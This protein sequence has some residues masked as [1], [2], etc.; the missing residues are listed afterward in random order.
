MGG[1]GSATNR[2]GDSAPDGSSEPTRGDSKRSL[3]PPRIKLHPAVR[4]RLQQALADLDVVDTDSVP[5]QASTEENTLDNQLRASIF[6]AALQCL[7][8]A[9]AFSEPA[10]RQHV[11]TF[12]GNARTLMQQG[13]ALSKAVQTLVTYSNDLLSA[14]DVL[15]QQELA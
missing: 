5:A 12:A 13:V 1:P 4:L 10:T 7:P 2:Q 6:D 14:R 3:Q 9:S 15:L 8:P 11:L